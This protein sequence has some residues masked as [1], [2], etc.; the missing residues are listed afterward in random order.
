LKV[1]YLFVILA[2]A[3]CLA[4][5]V[6]ARQALSG[7][8]KI[9]HVDFYDN[10]DDWAGFKFNNIT[11]SNNQ[12]NLHVESPVKSGILESP[13]RKTEFDFNEI[14]LSWN[15]LTGDSG[16]IFLVIAVSPDNE[17]WY[18]FNYQKWGILPASYYNYEEQMP[19]VKIKDIGWVDE[20]FI[21]LHQPMR[22]YKFAAS[23]FADEL[24]L[25][26]FDRA[27]VCYSNTNA[28]L[29]EYHIHTPAVKRIE[30]ISLPV[31][32]RSQHSLPDSIE[33][34]TCSP[35]CVAM[36]L[37]YHDREY[38]HLEVS[39][40][41]YDPYGDLYG[42]WPYNAQA[43]YIL[44][45]KKTWIGRHNTLNEFIDELKA[46]KP[47]IIN[48]AFEDNRLSAA[49][50]SRTSGHI[51]VIRGFDSDGN[52]LVNDPAGRD[53]EA[54]MNTYDFDELTAVWTGHS[55]VAYHLWPE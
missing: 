26:S 5:A 12:N 48:I 10:G 30:E 33:S 29:R 52:V 15:C 34:R 40:A 51:I 8:Y 3:A 46:G 44:G 13:S 24:N 27:A 4:L 21:K 54:G 20:D 2:F 41:V 23:C 31:P 28:S 47:V 7:D 22:Y 53:I 18:N 11:L 1:K 49:P 32:F 6:L 42:N 50:Y 45:M 55:G 37:N 39:G 25:L 9:H 16:A 43:A 17:T 19:P 38:N 36:V 35:T 14:L